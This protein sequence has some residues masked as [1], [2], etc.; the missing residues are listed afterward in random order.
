M[1]KTVRNVTVGVILTLGLAQSAAAVAV[2]F[3]RVRSSRPWIVALIEQAIERSRTFRTLVDTINASDG[4]VYVEEGHCGHGV[5]ACFVSVTIAGPNRLLWVRV[6][7]HKA[8]WDLM[9]DIGHELRHAIEVLSDPTVR[10]DETLYVFYALNPDSRSYGTP[11]AF[12]TDAAIGAGLDVRAELRR[13]TP[14]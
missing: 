11:D 14:R 6:D 1:T 7:T 2:T 12:E 9:G 3:P 4:I 5:R 10:N 13:H 8:D